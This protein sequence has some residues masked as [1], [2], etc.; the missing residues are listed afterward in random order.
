MKRRYK[1]FL[2]IVISFILVTIIYFFMPSQKLYYVSIG[3]EFCFNKFSTYNYN[4]YLKKLL[5]EVEYKLYTSNNFSTSKLN[6]LLTSNYKNIN[7]LLKNAEFVVLS[8]GNSE[9]NN[10]VDL[11]ASILR[12]FENNLNDIYLQLS[13]LNENIFV[14]GLWGK[15]YWEINEKIKHLTNKYNLYYIDIE[16]ANVI[17]YKEKLFMDYK[18]HEDISQ[19]IVNNK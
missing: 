15:K 19:Y 4:D 16:N 11:N 10:Y 7:F 9:L 1:L 5:P 2:I 6:I 12:D 17:N 13:N 8:I 18:T 14:I 3:D